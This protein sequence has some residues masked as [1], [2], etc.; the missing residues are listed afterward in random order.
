MAVLQMLVSLLAIGRPHNNETSSASHVCCPGIPARNLPNELAYL[1]RLVRRRDGGFLAVLP[2]DP[3]VES[4]SSLS[5]IAFATDFPLG[6]LD[7]RRLGRRLMSELLESELS[8]ASTSA[9]LDFLF[10]LL[11]IDLR[12]ALVRGDA[13]RGLAGLMAT[14]SSCGT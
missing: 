8:V 7:C 5:S 13:I 4:E 11:R 9:T 12:P 1:E 3:S 10:E 14:I 2:N 6:F